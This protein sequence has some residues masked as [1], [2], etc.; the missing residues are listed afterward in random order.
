M[1]RRRAATSTQHISDSNRRFNERVE[2]QFGKYTVEIRQAV[3][4]GTAL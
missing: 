2:K 4:R 3:E 1:H